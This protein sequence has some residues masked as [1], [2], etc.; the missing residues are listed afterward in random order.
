MTARR[1]VTSGCPVEATEVIITQ[2]PVAEAT[3]AT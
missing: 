2:L 1:R 3:K